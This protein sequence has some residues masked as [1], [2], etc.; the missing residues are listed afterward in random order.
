MKLAR[1]LTVAAVLSAAA[2][3]VAGGLV[4]ATG[5]GL[6]C[7]DWP[8][9]F[10]HVFPALFPVTSGVLFEHGHR[11][12][13]ALTGVLVLGS[14]VAVWRTGGT[15]DTQRLLAALAPLF[16]L[17]Q[18]LLGALTVLWRLP[19][20]VSLA[21]FVLAQ[22][23]FLTLLLLGWSLFESPNERQLAGPSGRID[24]LVAG[25]TALVTFGQ[26]V[27]GAWLRHIGTR[28]QLVEGFWRRIESELPCQTFPWCP[29]R[30]L[31]G[32]LPS[33]HVI[34]ESHRI[35]AALVVLAVAGLMVRFWRYRR[36][37]PRLYRLAL[38]S[39]LF[40][41]VQVLVGELSVRSYL[42]VVPVTLHLGGALFLFT[43]LTVLTLETWG[44]PGLAVDRERA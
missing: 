12:L 1:G 24:T 28:G 7:P 44:P 14:T 27:L 13:A 9:C 15:T 16:V 29:P 2:T 10:G 31:D 42:A 43:T 3:V 22:I 8:L 6:A 21:H 30:W 40:V 37:H 26:M 41:F 11:L 5:A 18:A 23:T 19:P 33:Y 20:M 32:M 34:Y 4:H 39:V 35:G 25:G 17:I 36:R 38:L